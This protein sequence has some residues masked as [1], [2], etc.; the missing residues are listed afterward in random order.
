MVLEDRVLRLEWRTD[1]HE[2]EIKEMKKMQHTISNEMEEFKRILST[3]RNL[4]MGAIAF[5]IIE[6]IGVLS[7][8]K[9]IF[10]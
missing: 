7:F 10:F 3:I 5:A 9:K 1:L 2:S 8:L 6:Q 4:L